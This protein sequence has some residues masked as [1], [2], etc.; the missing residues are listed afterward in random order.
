MTSNWSRLIGVIIG[1]STAAGVMALTERSVF[2]RERPTGPLLSECDGAL[3]DVVI[4]YVSE[5]APIVERAYHD[6]LTQLPADVTVNVVCPNC[7][8]FEDLSR[9]I[10]QT[11][12]TLRPVIADHPMTS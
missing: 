11:S 6:F 1:L 9:R 8:A 10:G 12:C 7:E 5:A 4:Q 2:D 3:C